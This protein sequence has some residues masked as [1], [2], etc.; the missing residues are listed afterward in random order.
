M[1]RLRCFLLWNGNAWADANIAQSRMQMCELFWMQ[2]TIPNVDV[3]RLQASVGQRDA[4]HVARHR[5]V[6]HRDRSGAPIIMEA[7]QI[8]NDSMTSGAN[9]SSASRRRS[10][11]PHSW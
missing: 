7:C 4:K 11:S 10:E 9:S 1:D 5:E 8:L 3:E 6:D 2:A